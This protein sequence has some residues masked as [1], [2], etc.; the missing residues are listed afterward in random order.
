MPKGYEKPSVL[1]IAVLKDDPILVKFLLDAGA[2]PNAM[3]GCFGSALHIACCS[4]KVNQYEMIHL[5]LEYGADVNRC[6]RDQDGRALKSPFVEYLRTRDDIVPDP[7]I[8][9]LLLSYG[10][11]I[12]IKQAQL[13]PRGQLRN[14]MPLLQKCP[15]LG[16]HVLSMSRPSDVDTTSLERICHAE[17]VPIESTEAVLEFTR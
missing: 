17:K 14:I 1:D 4:E 11:E 3:H 6:G 13:D 7:H 10:G 8:V 2:D 16:V 12:V 9:G 15:A 5:L